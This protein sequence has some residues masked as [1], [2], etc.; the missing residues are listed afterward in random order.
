MMST[1]NIE[2]VS[3]LECMMTEKLAAELK[4]KYGTR[5]L[6]VSDV[7]IGPECKREPDIDQQRRIHKDMLA[8]MRWFSILDPIAGMFKFRLPWDMEPITEYLDG[9]IHLP[10]FGRFLTHESRLI[11]QRGAGMKRYVNSRYEG[12]M[13]FF[14]QNLRAAIYPGGRCYDCTVFRDIVR[15]YLEKS[16]VDHEV[17]VLC[18]EIEDELERNGARWAAMQRKNCAAPT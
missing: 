3:V 7:R 17:D 6:F 10:V 11:V 18:S 16:V 15:S 9:S 4:I 12:Q 13:A 5:T 2:N 1:M 14:N 8:Q